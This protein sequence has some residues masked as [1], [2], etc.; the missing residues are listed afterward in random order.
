MRRHQ[1]TNQEDEILHDFDAKERV[2]RIMFVDRK[3]AV[4]PVTYRLCP[5]CGVSMERT[6]SVDGT[7]W[8]CAL[9]GCESREV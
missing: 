1:P 7:V 4:T 6:E 5:E 9:C 3:G 2:L 8:T